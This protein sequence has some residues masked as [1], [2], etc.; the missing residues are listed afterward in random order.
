MKCSSIAKAEFIK[1]YSLKTATKIQCSGLA[2][3]WMKSLELPQ[4][5]N[6]SEE[7]PNFVDK[8]NNIHP[9]YSSTIVTKS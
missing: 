8:L 3:R 4:L 6:G 2:D 7:F 9:N 1:K 5:M